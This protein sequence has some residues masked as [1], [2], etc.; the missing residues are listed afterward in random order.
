M[1]EDQYLRGYMRPDLIKYVLAHC[2]EIRPEKIVHLQD[3]VAW[4]EERLGES[5]A[6]SILAEALEGW[7]DYF[8]GDWSHLYGELGD[9]AH[10]FWFHNNQDQALFTLTWL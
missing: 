7:L 4:C 10:R 5:R 6:G 2:V 1:E 3:M 8:D 9:N